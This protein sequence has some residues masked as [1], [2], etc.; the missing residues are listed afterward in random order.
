MTI[1][2]KK[3][4]VL[5]VLLPALVA[6]NETTTNTPRTEISIQFE[7]MLEVEGTH[8]SGSSH[9][10][11]AQIDSSILD[12][13][14]DEF[15]KTLPAE[16]SPK[17]GDL[18]S[19]FFTEVESDI[20]GEC[21]FTTASGECSLV[22]TNV[23]VSYQEEKS[24]RS[25][26]F[27]TLGLAQNFLADFSARFSNVRSRY[28]FPRMEQSVAQFTILGVDQHLNS[29]D[30]ETLEST[31][32]EVFGD[33]LF[34]VG[35]D[36]DIL[37]AKYIYQ[38]QKDNKLEMHMMLTGVCQTCT[39]ESFG[40]IVDVV[41]ASTL[42]NF[43]LDLMENANAIGSTT[44]DS[45]ASVLYST[46]EEPK[47]LD[48]LDEDTFVIDES[49]EITKHSWFFWFGICAFLILGAGIIDFRKGLGASEKSGDNLSYK[50]DTSDSSE[51]SDSDEPDDMEDIELDTYNTAQ[52]FQVE[53][54]ADTT[55]NPWLV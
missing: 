29:E 14:Q 11:V 44:F 13:F 5:A 47:F 25:I 22:R 48:S 34:S 45:A 55:S 21:S 12:E 39:S 46:P 53:S 26:E 1:G 54:E 3:Y 17:D 32:L 36:T 18:P 19:I 28:M 38:E 35:G 8:K 15:Q 41:V 43:L 49:T 16:E 37:D 24:E 2:S 42:D 27:V 6:S 30:I 10:V 7:Y 50:C 23:L 33:T 4:L 9:L 20:F 40:E 51:A 31:I 52:R